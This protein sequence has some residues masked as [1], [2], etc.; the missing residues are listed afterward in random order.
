MW[1]LPVPLQLGAQL[2]LTC[3][4]HPHL[5]FLLPNAGSAAHSRT[6]SVYLNELK[7]FWKPIWLMKQPKASVCAS[8]CPG[9][10]FS[11]ALDPHSNCV[12]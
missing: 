4:C 5:A 12:L 1:R 3:L 10:T 11:I 2:A 6:S 9:P 7:P 8:H